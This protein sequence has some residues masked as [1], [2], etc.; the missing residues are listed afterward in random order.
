MGQ[1]QAL[2][3]A[4]NPG[5]RLVRHEAHHPFRHGH[6]VVVA[7]QAGHAVCVDFFTQGRLKNLQ[8][9]AGLIM[10]KFRVPLEAQHLVADVIGGERAKL[11]GGD[12]RGIVRQG[13]DLVLV[14]DQ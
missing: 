9:L 11:A 1:F 8:Q 12:D 2:G 7:R 6:A 3:L 14:A 5:L 10:D 13:G 4:L